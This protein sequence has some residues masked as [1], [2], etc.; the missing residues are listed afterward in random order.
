MPIFALYAKL[1]TGKLLKGAAVLTTTRPTA[2][3]CI[4]SIPFDK[5]FEIFG[6]PSEQVKEYVTKFAEEDEEAVNTVRRH[7]TSNIVIL[8]LCHI[9][10][11]CFIICSRL[12]KTVKLFGSESLNLPT[13][14]TDIYKKAVKIFYL[15]HNEEFRNKH[16]TRENFE[17]NDFPPKEEKKFEKLEKMAFEGIKE[18][19]LIFGGNEVRGMEDSALFYRLPD[20]EPDPFNNKGQFCF[21]HPTMPDFFAAEH[22]TNMSETELR[23]FVSMNT[24]ESKWQLVFQFLAGLMESKN[25]LLSKIIT[26]LL[27]LE[28]E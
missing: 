18:G 17:S 14:F 12:F 19:R 9:P 10:A 5:V 26:D 6:F 4:E 1:A 11:S 16:F 7:I 20:R 2:L 13:R 8:S 15:R 23:N 28:T 21:I 22:L 24:K 3:S 25:P 27:S